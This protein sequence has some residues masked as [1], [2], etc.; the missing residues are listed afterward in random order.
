MINFTR[1]AFSYL[2]GN[3]Q[4]PQIMRRRSAV[5]PYLSN[6][7]RFCMNLL[8]FTADTVPSGLLTELPFIVHQC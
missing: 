7:A 1:V 5:F 6:R 2:A 8:N 4:A 3:R